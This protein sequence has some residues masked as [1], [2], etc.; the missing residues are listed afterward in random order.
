MKLKFRPVVFA[1]AVLALTPTFARSEDDVAA[2]VPVLQPFGAPVEQQLKRAG[3]ID[4]DL[5]TLPQT[6]PEKF[7][8][9]EL[10]E[11]EP[12]P[13]ELPGSPAPVPTSPA[14]PVASAPAP[15]PLITFEGLD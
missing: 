8:R 15:A 2:T 6:P 5:R 1:A 14:P 4:I 11:P 7:E 9:P 12:N 13:V 3:S 10:E